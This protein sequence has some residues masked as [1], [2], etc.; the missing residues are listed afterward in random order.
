MESTSLEV[1]FLREASAAIKEASAIALV[2]TESSEIIIITEECSSV[3]IIAKITM[4]ASTMVE[5]EIS[6]MAEE[7]TMVEE[8]TDIIDIIQ[9]TYDY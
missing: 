6:I 5:E 2:I 8:V 1:T 7:V 4:E 3:V 9:S